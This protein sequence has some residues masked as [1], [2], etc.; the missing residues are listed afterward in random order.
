MTRYFAPILIALL[1]ASALFA[2][3]KEIAPSLRQACGIT[4]EDCR[5]AEK[6]STV[7]LFDLYA[8]AVRNT[9]KMQIERENVI[10][11]EARRDQAIGSFFPKISLRAT[12]ALP[13]NDYGQNFSPGFRTGVLLY[14]RQPIITGLDE[15]S[16]LKG[17]KHDIRLR[18]YTLCYTA[19]RLLY[20]IAYGYYNVLQIST[21][22]ES[23]NEV[24]KLYTKNLQELQRRVSL[25]KSRQSEVLRT[26]SQIFKI[27]AEIR[28]LTNELE[29]ARLL[30]ATL[31]GVPME[32]REI[33]GIA[34]IPAPADIRAKVKTLVDARWDIRAASEEV[35]YSEAQLLAAKG[36]H[37]PSLYLEGAYRLYQPN[38]TGPDY[39][40]G[41]G[42]EIPIFSG[43]AVSA[44]IR[45]SESA[46]RQSELRLNNARRTAE[47]DIVDSYQSWETSGQEEE[48]YRRAYLAA[49]ENYQTSLNDYRYNLVTILDVIT[50]LTSLQGAQDDYARIML[51]HRLNRV[52][53]GI[54]T[55][56]FSGEGIRILRQ[57]G[58]GQKKSGER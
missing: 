37:L 35:K 38:A 34:D 12:K 32:G 1:A 51:Q 22:L 39:Y 18:N 26:R 10:Q 14:G 31:T 24:L 15:W 30:L 53:L 29:R 9:E 16:R 7:G 25:G 40:F 48:A 58:T 5:S 49:K 45:E 23:R 28:S 55:S 56:E 41:L 21:S 57:D 19:T 54:A 50:S 3:G 6:K 20:D 42:A 13:N 2:G 43:G 17:A 11:A 8:L 46:L 52:R 44:K 36:G 27:E 47:Q 4:D 33:R